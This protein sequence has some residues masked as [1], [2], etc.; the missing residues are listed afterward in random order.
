MNAYYLGSEL[1][2]RDYVLNYLKEKQSTISLAGTYKIKGVVSVDGKLKVSSI[3][4]LTKVNCNC[5]DTITEVLNTM[6]KWNPGL[7]DGKKV[8]SNVQFTIAF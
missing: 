7:E 6:I 5:E 3:I 8:S 2:I 4:Q 1:A